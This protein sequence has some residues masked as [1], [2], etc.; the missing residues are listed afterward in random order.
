VSQGRI[1][2]PTLTRLMSENAA[3]LYG[4]FPRKGII[5]V[6]ADADLVVV[7]MEKEV[8]IERSRLYTKQKDGARLFD[9]WHA[10]GMPIV[11]IVRGAVVMR[12]G[13]VVGRPGYG[14]CISPLGQ[15]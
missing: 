2:L 3:R 15:G 5:Q 8:T 6:G 10:V 12:N 1:E 13:E 4:I 9:G 7:D 14:E 11:T